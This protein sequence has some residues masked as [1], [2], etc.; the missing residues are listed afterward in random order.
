MHASRAS[1]VQTSAPLRPVA[2]LIKPSTRVPA[3]AS[4]HAATLRPAPS[5]IGAPCVSSC[6][7]GSNGPVPLMQCR[8][9]S[10]VLVHPAEGPISGL[11]LSMTSPPSNAVGLYAGILAFIYVLQTLSIV[12]IRNGKQ[13]SMGDG[14]DKLLACRVRVRCAFIVISTMLC[15]RLQR[16][17]RR[18]LF[19]HSLCLRV[20]A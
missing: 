6:R 20:Y 18:S 13:I 19:E 11:V 8:A 15:I 1:A 2:F 14:G 17:M 5:I 16:S 12:A 7:P 9:T 10:T 4:H 3:R